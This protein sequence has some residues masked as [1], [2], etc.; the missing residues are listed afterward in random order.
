MKLIA[1]FFNL[2]FLAG[3]ILLLIFTVLSGSSRHR[4]LNKFYWL[5]A[6]TSNIPNAPASRSA[7]TFWGVCD[8]NDYSNCLLGPAYPIS[9]VDNFETTRNIPEK[10]SSQ[11]NTFYYLS[12]F[13]FA[14]CL[15]ALGF[16]GLAFIIDILGFC[17]LI[18][19]KIV[20][21][22][23]SIA[24]FFMAGFAAF[25]TAVVVL[26]RSAFHSDDLYAHIGVKSMA[27]MWAAFACL[28]ICWVITLSANIVNSY[29]KNI[30]R[31][32][33]EKGNNQSQQQ[34]HHQTGAAGIRD[35]S[36]FTRA[37]NV[38]DENQNGGGIRF[39]KIKR[40]Q[41]VNDEDSV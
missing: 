40:N 4:P 19:D 5:E 1:T 20:I 24:L 26:A 33:G 3:A 14:F 9:P 17:F 13:A 12:R 7:W 6:D 22:L 39:F 8:K 16:A 21:F 31:V 35:D 36:S 15:I 28:I 18:I 37:K 34:Q 41:K 38:D 32:N 25:Q 30:N 11:E 10:F 23:I 27:I 29:K 2:F